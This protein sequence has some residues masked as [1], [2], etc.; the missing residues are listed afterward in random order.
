MVELSF[1]R[2]VETPTNVRDCCGGRYKIVYG[3]P[4]IVKNK[5]AGL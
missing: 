4:S 2:L 3:L 1:T 5:S